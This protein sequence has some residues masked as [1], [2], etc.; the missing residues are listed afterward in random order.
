[1]DNVVAVCFSCHRELDENPIAKVSFFLELLGQERFNALNER[2]ERL[3]PQI[4]KVE[5]KLNL[6]E[7]I[8]TL[9][10]RE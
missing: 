10:V 2:A 8:K 5:L 6:Q 4:D 1:V 3:K 9:E 7:K